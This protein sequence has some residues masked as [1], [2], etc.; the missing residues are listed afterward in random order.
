MGFKDVK[1]GGK[2]IIA[3]L[4]V[5]LIF[6]GISAYQ[7]FSLR[8]LAQLQDEGAGR[9]EDA[10]ALNDIKIDIE[11]IYPVI[12][13]AVINR[14][15][16]A[17]YKEFEEV[18]DKAENNIKLLAELADTDA[19]RDEAE[20]A[21][22][23]YKAYIDIAGNKMFPLIEESG[24]AAQRAADAVA[25]ANIETRVGKVYAVIADAVI[26]RNLA[27]TRIDFSKVK[28]E[29]M[30]DIAEVYKQVD[31]V[32]ERE[33][34][35]EF[36]SHYN[37]YLDIFE[38]KM[39]PILAQSGSVN[40]GKIRALDD[41]I[42]GVRNLTLNAL[43]KIV[44]S[45]E[46]EAKQ[47][48]ADEK[49]IRELD[50]LIDGI[51]D[52]LLVPISE[53]E[54][55]LEKETVEADELFDA[56]GKRTTLL[57][58]IISTIAVIIS[59]LLAL[60]ITRGITNPIA[61]GV[62]FAQKMADGDLTEN[63]NV[64]RKDEVGVLANALNKMVN[65]LRNMVLQILDGSSEIASS[66]EEMSA[67]AQ[68]LSEGAQSQASTL[69]ET[70][71][72]VEELT[73]SVEQVS[74][75]AQ[76]QTSAVEQSTASMEQVQKSIDE[77]SKT[78]ENVSEI[79][80]ESV[81]KSS[82]GA[83]TVGKAVVAINLISESSDKIAGIINVISDIADQTNL[84]ALNASIEAA[85]AGEH[86]RGFAV[87]ADEVSKL[88]DRSASSTKEI[89]ELIKESV[90]NVKNGVELAQESKT[91]MEEITEGAQK[92]ADMINN[93]ASALEQ[94]VTAVEELSGA[95]KNIS[96]MSQSIS[97]ATE[98]QSTN[99]KQTS[100]AI[101]DVNEIT[102]Q[103]ASAAEE[104]AAST[105]EMS[106]M[107][108]QLQGLVSQFKVEGGKEELQALPEA[109]TQKESAVKKERIKTAKEVKEKKEKEEVTEIRLKEDAA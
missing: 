91:S 80:N 18:K 84:L 76:S 85:R 94:Q 35:E 13:D 53:M 21:G 74:E 89:E 25:I 38:S 78:L 75:H 72:S 50:G 19:E 90:K 104:M 95:I 47:A 68:Q 5:I 77:V 40:M 34:A 62:I 73:T 43:H 69:E 4:A 48:M 106:G 71:T 11:E 107:A 45:L 60:T 24:D 92:S 6:G 27:E 49:E 52:A 97:A 46:E 51:R 32:E 108:Q 57:T 1:I 67:S 87:V 102:Q 8:K 109:K 20:E 70:S 59:L 86:G 81:A 101:E 44:L 39:L 33:W 41:D 17:T 22:E 55:S 2:L 54:K 15:L 105:E 61:Q 79:A 26:N 30:K 42:D 83:E 56:I 23:A 14:D 66:S 16:D 37:N 31:T 96:E 88:A 7:V 100:K 82:G 9:A 98:E 3:F 64:E 28:E 36:E 103:A 29:A 12:A 99:A 63:L 10:L 93:L 65:N 58:I